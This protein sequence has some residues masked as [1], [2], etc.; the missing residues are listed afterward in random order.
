MIK[1]NAM[2]LDYEPRKKI[3]PKL[4]EFVSP[5]GYREPEMSEFESA[6]LCGAIKTFRPK[7]ILEVG[8]A[9][10]ATTAIILQ[11]LEDIG[12][13]YEMYSIDAAEKFYRD[14]TKPSGFMA[15][16]AMENNLLN[17]PHTTLNGKHEF[18]LGKFLP[19]VID[20]IGGGIDLVV[21][22]TRHVMPGEGM[23]FLAMLPYL[24][25]GSIVVLHDVTYNQGKVQNIN[26]HATTVL[27]SAVTANKFVN[28]LPD[29]GNRKY[30]YP[31]IAAFQIN[32]QT[33]ANIENIFLSMILRW[34]YM[35][36]QEELNIY[37]AHYLKHYPQEL[38][39]IFNEAFKMNL[40][41]LVMVS[42]S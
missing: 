14:K 23:D 18:H 38:C 26:G 11:A 19:Q 7:K 39:A 27:F 31:N 34:A 22:D 41:N 16:F 3:L 33:A 9:G 28:F 2:P 10:G 15:M 24:K 1:I 32:E 37:W 5:Q 25:P 13:P 20:S 8:V 4:P 36:S 30:V 29:D 21:L 12:E 40:Y 17:P 35:P 42:Y 6:F